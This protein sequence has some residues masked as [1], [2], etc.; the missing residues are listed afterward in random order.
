MRAACW[1]PIIRVSR[2]FRYPILRAGHRIPSFRQQ[3]SWGCTKLLNR[4]I[5]SYE[6]PVTNR[7]SDPFILGSSDFEYA[8]PTEHRCYIFKYLGARAR[9]LCLRTNYR[10]ARIGPCPI[11]SKVDIAY[12]VLPYFPKQV[13]PRQYQMVG[14]KPN[15]RPAPRIFIQIRRKSLL[16]SVRIY[17][18]PT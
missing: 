3:L 13:M 5:H 15:I 11:R 8:P 7:Y 10:I 14:R 2:Q 16:R 6:V 4:S 9:H 12:A 17:F 1:P 18:R